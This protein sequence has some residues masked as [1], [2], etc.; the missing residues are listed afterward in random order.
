M[1]T[2]IGIM[3]KF[4]HNKLSVNILVNNLLNVTNIHNTATIGGAHSN[5]NNTA[6]VAIG[7]FFSININYT[8]K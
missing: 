2:D 6:S 7:R 4:A 1:L 5:G 3:R 8:L